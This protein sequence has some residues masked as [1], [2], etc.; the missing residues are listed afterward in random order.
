MKLIK[1]IK[2]KLKKE[3]FMTPLPK[4]KPIQS[5]VIFE[6]KKIDKQVRKLTKEITLKEL[7]N[8]LDE[9]EVS[10]SKELI[11]AYE[12]EQPTK[13]AIWRGNYTKQFKAWVDDANSS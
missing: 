10:Y 9:E 2:A 4:K 5:V 12:K 7:E 11:E 6:D 1:K 8:E 13:H 3:V